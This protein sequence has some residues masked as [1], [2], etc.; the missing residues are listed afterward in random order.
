MEPS[1]IFVDRVIMWK[2][3]LIKFWGF[4]RHNRSAEGEVSG[5]EGGEN[6]GA[7]LATL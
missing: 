1:N 6:A 3:S 5:G 2:V 4:R 7:V